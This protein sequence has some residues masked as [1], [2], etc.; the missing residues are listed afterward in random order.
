MADFKFN[1][2]G[3]A[4]LEKQFGQELEKA[5]AEANMAAAR[6]ATPEGKARAFAKVLQKHGVE[7]VNEAALRRRFGG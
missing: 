3:L 5:E 4:D 1:K 7:N 6:E 2:K